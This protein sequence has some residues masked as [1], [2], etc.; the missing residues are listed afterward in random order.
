MKQ[1]EKGENFFATSLDFEEKNNF[2]EGHL[3]Y[4]PGLPEETKKFYLVFRVLHY[5]LF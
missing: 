4:L 1:R 2:V 5:P 3:K